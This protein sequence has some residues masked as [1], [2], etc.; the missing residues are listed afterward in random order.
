MTAIGIQRQLQPSLVGVIE[1]IEKRL[2]LGDVD[3]HRHV[4]PRARLPNRIELR[5]VHAQT[6]AVRLAIEH[7]EVLEH[8]QADRTRFDV[9]FELGRRFRSRSG[10]DVT[11]VDVGEQ[12]HAIRVGAVL[13]RLHTLSD[14]IAPSATQVHEQ[15]KVVGVHPFDHASELVVRDR[16]RLMTVDVDDRILRPWHG[17][18]RDDQHRLRL[19]LANRRRVQLRLAPLRGTR[20]NLWHPSAHSPRAGDPARRR[21]LSPF[22]A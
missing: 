11:E 20:P 21:L 17:V 22:A 6:T 16:R 4:E 15:T 7:A 14:S 5:L 13:D 8:L 18:L 3:Q 9:R 19:V 1:R 12:H 10:T 2:R